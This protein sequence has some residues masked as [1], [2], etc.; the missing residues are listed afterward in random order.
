M[1]HEKHEKVEHHGPSDAMYWGIWASLLFLTA[2]TVLVS[3]LESGLNAG[4]IVI[5]IATLKSLLVL[6]F[7]MHLKYDDE[8]FSNMV[9]VAISTLLLVLLLIFVDYPF[10]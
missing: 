5:S 3:F 9:L 1:N 4:T 8:V 6:V 7:F 10:R 2:T